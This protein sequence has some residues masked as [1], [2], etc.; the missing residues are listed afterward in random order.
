MD[1]PHREA[2]KRAWRKLKSGAHGRL[3]LPTSWQP[4][5][6]AKPWRSW[7]PWPWARRHSWVSRSWQPGGGKETA[8]YY[9]EGQGCLAPCCCGEAV[10]EWCDLRGPRGPSSA[11]RTSNSRACRNACVKHRCARG[12]VAMAPGVTS[13]FPEGAVSSSLPLSRM[14]STQ[15]ERTSNPRKRWH[16]VSG[17]CQASSGLRGGVLTL[18]GLAAAGLADLVIS[19]L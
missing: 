3:I 9:K 5:G 14:P 4:C 1:A 12:S 2:G 6:W 7:Q 17:H 18:A 10:A 8:R 11:Q 16:A 15:S 19:L 13:V